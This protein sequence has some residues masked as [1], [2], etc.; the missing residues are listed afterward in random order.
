MIFFFHS[1]QFSSLFVT[2]FH[3]LSDI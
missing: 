2:S 3:I 1:M